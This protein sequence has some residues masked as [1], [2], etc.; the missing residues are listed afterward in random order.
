[1]LL[2]L[3]EILTEQ[4]TLFPAGEYELPTSV[5]HTNEAEFDPK[6]AEHLLGHAYKG[7]VAHCNAIIFGRLPRGTLLCCSHNF[8]LQFGGLVATESLP[9]AML[10]DL[11]LLA[12]T[13]RMPTEITELTAECVLL[14]RWGHGTWGHWLAE[15][16][17][18]AALVERR[19]PGRFQY[20]I[21]DYGGTAYEAA[22]HDSLHAYG[23]DSHRLI[24]VTSSKSHV[25][26]NA[27]IVTPIWSDHAPHPAALDLMRGAVRLSRYKSGREKIALMR[28]DWATRTIANGDEVERVLREE[29]FTITDAASLPFLD[30]VRMFQSAQIVFGVI[31]SGFTGLIYSPNKVR[32]LG[33]GP[34][35]WGDRFFYALAQHR[36]GRWS[37]VRGRS[38]WDGDGLMR[39]APFEVSIQALRDGLNKVD[40]DDV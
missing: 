19:Y 12:N 27:R 28:R 9:H 11:A 14:T 30:Q 3:T 31:G 10:G 16:V 26:V 37:E 15:I 17:P 38:H 36:C 7:R 21:P 22:V 13:I 35:S 20:A 6:W 34:A 18:M 2:Q 1:M 24:P 23:I 5:V 25:L 33:V 29:G 8:V 40:G 39:D 4:E 32:V